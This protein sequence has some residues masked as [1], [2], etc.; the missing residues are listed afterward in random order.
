MAARRPPMSESGL[1]EGKTVFKEEKM[2]TTE[3]ADELGTELTAATKRK[4]NVINR[5]GTILYSGDASRIGTFHEGARF[6]IRTGRPVY[7]KQGEEKK[8]R[9]ALPGVN[10]PVFF[11]KEVIGAVGISGTPEEVGLLGTAVVRLTELMLKQKMIMNEADWKQ[12]AQEFLLDELLNEKADLKKVEQKSRILQIRWPEPFA[13]IVF[14]L[15][16]EKGKFS[17][18]E[19]FRKCLD[20]DRGVFLAGFV[21]A[22]TYVVLADSAGTDPLV[23]TQKLTVQCKKW[24]AEVHA[25]WTPPCHNLEEVSQAFRKA[26]RCSR[27]TEE[28][29]SATCDWEDV[30]L[31]D[32]AEEEQK[33]QFCQQIL[34]HLSDELKKTIEIFFANDLKVRETAKK[35]YLH[36]NTL[37]YRLD[38]ITRLTGCDPRTFRG[39]FLLQLALKLE[40]TIEK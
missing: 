11:E 40:R 6:A 27:L 1:L 32:S 29:I 20:R 33:I 5:D 17:S 19:D 38:K 28:T 16:Q 9:G 10:F 15:R 2:I 26:Q 30:L 39:A 23:L 35:L 24:F 13:L 3:M 7:I 14:Q 4:I 22:E 34:P 37:S 25:A 21:D 18:G 31:L 12:R 8:W 36:R